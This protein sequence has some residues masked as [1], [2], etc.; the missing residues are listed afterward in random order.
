M[1][2]ALLRL[3]C[4]PGMPEIPQFT[5][6]RPPAVPGAKV[7]TF[8]VFIPPA[9]SHRLH[10]CDPTAMLSVPRSQVVIIKYIQRHPFFIF[11][12]QQGW[13]VWNQSLPLSSGFLPAPGNYQQRAG[14]DCS[15]SRKTQRGRAGSASPRGE[16]EE[17]EQGPCWGSP[18]SSE[19]CSAPSAP[20]AP[21]L[22]PGAERSPRVPRGPKNED[23]E[24]RSESSG[25]SPT[26]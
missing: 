17:G 1:V 25:I 19:G 3:Q 21:V 5:L 26:G 14:R 24:E 2:A 18:G 7:M 23:G 6:S 11:F 10:R 9:C 22:S 20:S 8:K 4:T 16:G 13:R 12:F 15:R